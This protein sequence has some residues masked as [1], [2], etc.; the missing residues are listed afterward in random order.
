MEN[1]HT[2]YGASTVARSNGANGSNRLFAD[3][4]ITNLE[5]REYFC[6][7]SCMPNAWLQ[8]ACLIFGLCFVLS[9][10]PRFS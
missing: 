9:V 2:F 10:V 6:R 1:A 3:S 5:I 8:R 4:I 7:D